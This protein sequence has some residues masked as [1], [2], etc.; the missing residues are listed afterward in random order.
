MPIELREVITAG[1]A[2]A[3]SPDLVLMAIKLASEKVIEWP[4]KCSLVI[5]QGDVRQAFDNLNPRQ[6][7]DAL[8]VHNVLKERFLDPKVRSRNSLDTR[9]WPRDDSESRSGIHVAPKPK[10]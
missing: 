9:R 3:H 7:Y 10:K 8:D 5:G 4:Q 1:Y 6:L 2:K